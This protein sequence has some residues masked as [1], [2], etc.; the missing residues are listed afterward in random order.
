MAEVH[1]TMRQVYRAS[2]VSTRRQ[3]WLFAF[4]CVLFVACNVVALAQA[5]T[6]SNPDPITALVT[7]Q[8]ITMVGMLIYGAGTLRE[9]FAQVRK[10]LEDLEREYVRKDLFTA[11]M[12]ALARRVDEFER[13]HHPPR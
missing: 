2:D 9:Q 8:N 3:V 5:S 6:P 12:G 13:T 11:E 7:P 1:L 4:G 10:K